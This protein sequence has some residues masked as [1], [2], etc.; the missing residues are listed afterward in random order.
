[1]VAATPRAAEVFKK[2]L[3]LISN[4]STFLLFITSPFGNILLIAVVSLTGPLLNRHA[5]LVA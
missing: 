5:T 3:R 2:F 4:S 1:M